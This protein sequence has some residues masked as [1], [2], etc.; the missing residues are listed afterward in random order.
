M[1]AKHSNNNRQRKRKKK[2]HRSSSLSKGQSSVSYKNFNQYFS[3]YQQLMDIHLK[4][5]AEYYNFFYYSNDKERVRL[6]RN[7]SSTMKNIREFE[8]QIHPEFKESFLK[9]IEGGHFDLTYS[10]NHR[11]TEQDIS[12][13]QESD[14]SDPH[15]LHTQQSK[16]YINDTE[17]S[18]GTMEEYKEFKESIQ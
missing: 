7:F 3:R 13:P 2:T 8:K 18:I 12:R 9:R 14:A 6:E 15:L 11:L 17:E 5:R 16:E 10:Q 1:S 4:A